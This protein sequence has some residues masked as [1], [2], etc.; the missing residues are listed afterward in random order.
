[1]TYPPPHPSLIAQRTMRTILLFLLLASCRCCF[2]QTDINGVAVG[3]WSEPVRDSDG[4]DGHMLRGRLLVYYAQG[5]AQTNSGC[6]GHA[7]VYLELLHPDWAG[8]STMEIF[9][10]KEDVHFE[11]RDE[12]DK[13]IPRENIPIKGT[14]LPRDWITVRSDSTVLLRADQPF[15]GSQSKPEGLMILVPTGCWVIRPA[16][17]N[18]FFLSATFYPTTNRSYH[19][20]SPEPSPKYHL[21]QGTLKFP[22]VKIPVKKDPSTTTK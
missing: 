6:W 15:Q 21:W 3:D 10:D 18:D 4:S 17:T 22:K 19:S 7:P 9:Y 13:P 20:F 16:A 12:F 5:Q 11:M 2:C 8:H 14:D 1:L